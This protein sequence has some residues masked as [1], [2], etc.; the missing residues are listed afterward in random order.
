MNVVERIPVGSFE[1][2]MRLFLEERKEGERNGRVYT[3]RI[4]P[5]WEIGLTSPSFLSC[6]SVSSLGGKNHVSFVNSIHTY[7]GGTHLQSINSQLSDMIQSALKKRGFPQ[8]THSFIYL[9]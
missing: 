6:N 7:R 1:D 2:Y 5:R 3:K 8:V 4:H 9:F